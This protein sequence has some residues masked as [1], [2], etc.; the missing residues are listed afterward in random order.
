MALGTASILHTPNK[1]VPSDGKVETDAGAL[2]S[3][4]KGHSQHLLLSDRSVTLS[5]APDRPFVDAAA[6]VE[7]VGVW[8]FQA[9]G[10]ISKASPIM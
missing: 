5:C 8:K 2:R 7:A 4:S 6:G 10:R 9:V 1:R 3:L